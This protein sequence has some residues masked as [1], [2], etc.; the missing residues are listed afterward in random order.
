LNVQFLGCPID[1][2]SCGDDT[3]VPISQRCDGTK[4]CPNGKDELDCNILIEYMNP[5]DV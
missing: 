1:S 4:Q 2:F 5:I 3:C